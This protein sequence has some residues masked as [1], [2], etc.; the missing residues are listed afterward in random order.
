ME[1]A[2]VYRTGVMDAAA[3]AEAGYRGLKKG[4]VVII[5][6]LRNKL[7]ALAVRLGP[8]KVVVAVTRRMNE[9]T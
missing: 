5:P 6:G 1:G 8:R 7:I 2:R 4:K 9:K 3:V